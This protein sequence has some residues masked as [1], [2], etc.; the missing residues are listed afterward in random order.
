MSFDR[1]A[2]CSVGVYEEAVGGIVS[3]EACDRVV[4]F[5]VG[6][7]GKSKWMG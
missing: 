7:V 1:L 4:E 5:N 3:V 2:D 6:S